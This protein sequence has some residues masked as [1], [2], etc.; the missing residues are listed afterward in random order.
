MKLVASQYRFDEFDVNPKQTEHRDIHINERVHA[1]KPKPSGVI[2]ERSLNGS[3]TTRYRS[4]LKIRK[5]RYQ[6]VINQ[7]D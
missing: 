4:G 1:V 3:V 6:F 7:N 2:L 5:R